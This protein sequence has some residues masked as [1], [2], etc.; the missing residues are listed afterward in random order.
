VPNDNLARA[1][2]LD[3]DAATALLDRPDAAEARF[4]G[5]T[6]PHLGRLVAVARRIL[7]SE[8][9]AWDAVQEGLTALWKE[10]IVPDDPRGWLVRTVVFRSLHASRT[11]QRRRRHEETGAERRPEH[12]G[13]EED[14]TRGLESRELRVLLD[15][16][17]AKLSPEFRRVIELREFHAMDYDSISKSTGVPVG[18]VRSRLNRARSAL[19]RILEP[20]ISRY[21]DGRLSEDAPR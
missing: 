20:K 15:E 2:T 3:P 13:A 14:P 7:G 4:A 9:L 8:D 17:I 16:A 5:M 11:R 19:R 21:W 18:T 12:T 10:S 6:R 1:A